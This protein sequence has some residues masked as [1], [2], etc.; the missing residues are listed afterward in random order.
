MLIFLNGASDLDYIV[1]KGNFGKL[2]LWPIGVNIVWKYD[3]MC[4]T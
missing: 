1:F 4:V 2:L 3:H